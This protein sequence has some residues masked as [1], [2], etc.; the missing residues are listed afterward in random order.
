MLFAWSFLVLPIF[1]GPAPYE[2]F[3]WPPSQGKIASSL[4][5]QVTLCFLCLF[6]ALSHSNMYHSSWLCM[7]LTLLEVELLKSGTDTYLSKFR[8]VWFSVFSP[9]WILLI[10]VPDGEG[11]FRTVYL[12]FLHRMIFISKVEVWSCSSIKIY[13]C[14]PRIEPE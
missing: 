12:R 7:P 9:P 2:A 4:C 10:L 8:L 6:S 13:F 1:D 3:S 11:D 14:H 5:Y